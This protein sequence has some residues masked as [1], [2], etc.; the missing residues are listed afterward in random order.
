MYITSTWLLLV[1]ALPAK[2]ARARVQAWRRLQRVGAVPL[3]NSAY[4][5]PCSADGREDLEWIRN[6]IVAIGGQAMV[7]IAE[8]TDAAAHDEIVSTFRTA[9]SQEFDE[10]ARDASTLL[11]RSSSTAAKRSRR[12]LTQA[13]RRLRERFDEVV[14]IDFFGT[15]GRDR[16]ADLLAR[17]EHGTRRGDVM[18]TI[19]RSAILDPA[20]YRGKAWLTRPRPGVDR[21]SSAWL[22]RRFIDPDATF[23]FGDPS[24][25][26]AAI[27][28]DTFE[29]EFGHRANHCTFETL[30][31]RF[32]VADP[33]VQWI[34][35][36]VHDL[37]LKE[38]AFNEPD[39]ATVGR[40]VEGLRRSQPDDQ[41]LLVQG[42]ATFEALY[43]SHADPETGGTRRRRTANAKRPGARRR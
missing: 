19:T 5:L 12:H 13:A 38:N 21:M 25:A 10:L 41:A 34:A 4:V 16:V 1:Y 28:F 40:M 11:K 18:K 14:R 22:I 20:G 15:P 3:K 17:I 33:A 7:L 6:E 24:K 32:G 23:I 8:T 31:E 37:D 2:H 42:I 30:C 29:A 26:P 9:R 36:I 39:A 27:P 35:R 43:Q